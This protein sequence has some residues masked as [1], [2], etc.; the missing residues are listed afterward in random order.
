MKKQISEI[1]SEKPYHSQNFVKEENDV[2]EK[3]VGYSE[4]WYIKNDV[5]LEIEL[6]YEMQKEDKKYLIKLEYSRLE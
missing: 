4:K 2:K 3:L 5:K 6:K 1:Y